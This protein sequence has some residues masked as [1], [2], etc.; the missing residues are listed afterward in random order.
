MQFKIANLYRF[1]R[2]QQQ[3][4]QQQYYYILLVGVT[5]EG[6]MV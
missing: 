2:Q 5:V 6:G 1:L 4:Q 3:Q